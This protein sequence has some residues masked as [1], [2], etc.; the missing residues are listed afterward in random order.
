MWTLNQHQQFV[1][2]DALRKK[3]K[4]SVFTDPEVSAF[5]RYLEY[6]LLPTYHKTRNKRVIRIINWPSYVGKTSYVREIPFANPMTG[7]I[8]GSCLVHQVKVNFKTK[9]PVKIEPH[10]IDRRGI[11]RDSPPRRALLSPNRTIQHPSI[12]QWLCPV[13]QIEIIM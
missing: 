4:T 10:E 9:Q 13:I 7:E 8:L 1:L 2:L 3:L 5:V 12:Q 11:T 6:N